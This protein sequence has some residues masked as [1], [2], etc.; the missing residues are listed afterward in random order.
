M[1]TNF[2]S[3]GSLSSKCPCSVSQGIQVKTEINQFL[4]KVVEGMLSDR[5]AT[6]ET[7]FQKHN[8]E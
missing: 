3:F 2:N 8:Q 6:A 1:D 5:T 7:G 4:K